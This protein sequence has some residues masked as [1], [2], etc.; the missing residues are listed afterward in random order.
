MQQRVTDTTACERALK[1]VRNWAS[2]VYG[3]SRVEVREWL[4]SA[5]GWSPSRQKAADAEARSVDSAL[6]HAEVCMHVVLTLHTRTLRSQRS[7]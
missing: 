4:T 1:T 5:Q 2:G 6:R 7:M 3:L